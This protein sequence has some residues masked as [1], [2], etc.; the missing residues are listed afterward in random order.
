MIVN[1]AVWYLY[2]AQE[3][4]YVGDEAVV[5]P[6]GKTQRKG[7]DFGFRYQLTTCFLEHGL[8]L[9]ACPQHRWTKREG[10]YLWRG[11]Y[12]EKRAFGKGFKR[13][14]CLD[15]TAAFNPR[16][17]HRP[18]I[19]P[20]FLLFASSWSTSVG[21]WC[22]S[23][24]VIMLVYTRIGVLHGCRLDGFFS[25]VIGT[26]VPVVRIVVFLWDHTVLI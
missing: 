24:I 1:S 18:L 26:I 9:H 5:E 17:L 14:F 25:H 3:F 23:F 6:S 19:H 16:H 10:P 2:R 7:F 12:F 8:Y 15:N 11:P 22:W 21:W 13:L 20:N 4:V